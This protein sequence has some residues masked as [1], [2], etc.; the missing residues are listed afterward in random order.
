MM[1][2]LADVLAKSSRKLSF[3]L[4]LT[5]GQ[6][7]VRDFGLDHEAHGFGLGN[8]DQVIGLRFWNLLNSTQL[9]L[10]VIIM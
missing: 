8:E 2:Y 10:F 9:W 3:A 5:S 1:K 6:Q 4:A 7:K